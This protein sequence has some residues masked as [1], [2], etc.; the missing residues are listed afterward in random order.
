[1]DLY[2]GFLSF[3]DPYRAGEWA[4]RHIPFAIRSGSISD[5]CSL[6]RK[7]RNKGIRLGRPLFKAGKA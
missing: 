7:V 4:G 3:P 1:M 5:P 6:G 2:P